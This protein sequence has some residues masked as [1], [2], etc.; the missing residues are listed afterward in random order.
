[1]EACSG[2]HIRLRSLLQWPKWLIWQANLWLLSVS[3]V[4]QTQ[5]GHESHLAFPRSACTSLDPCHVIIRGKSTPSLFFYFFHLLW[6]FVELTRYLGK[7]HTIRS[8]THALWNKA[9]P[10]RRRHRRCR[11]Q[12]RP[13]VGRSDSEKKTPHFK[14]KYHQ[15]LDRA[16]YQRRPTD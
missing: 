5:A 8:S 10:D 9:G 2:L 15:H 11:S 1:M 12:N 16:I 3:S 6:P 4:T 14:A 13:F 7:N